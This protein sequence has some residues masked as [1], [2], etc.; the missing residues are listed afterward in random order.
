[1]LAC[2]AV[3]AAIA[4]AIPFAM[5]SAIRSSQAA[6]KAGNLRAALSDALTAQT[7][8]PYAATPRLQRALVLEQGRHFAR[9]R[10]AIVQATKREATNWQL[11]LVRSRIDAESGHP[12]RAV[13]DYRRAHV[14]NPLSPATQE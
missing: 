1:V 3:A 13:R 11:W 6:A 4:I 10:A 2:A 9:A 7:L 14:L 12:L 5:T 8:E